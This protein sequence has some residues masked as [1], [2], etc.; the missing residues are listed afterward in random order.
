MRAATDKK[1]PNR[2]LGGVLMATSSIFAHVEIT[3][4]KKAERF[5]AALEESERAQAKKKRTA[6]AIPV[7]RDAN[8]IRKLMAKRFPVK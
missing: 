1:E 3:D 6:P 2:Q 7:M 8:D 4:Q 5:V